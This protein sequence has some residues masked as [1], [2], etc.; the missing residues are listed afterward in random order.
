MNSFV[1]ALVALF[2]SVSASFQPLAVAELESEPPSPEAV[3]LA[4]FLAVKN[5]P[6]PAD[7][8]VQYDNWELIVALSNA[9][10]S[11]GRHMA[12]SFNAWGIKDFRSGSVKFGKTRD[13][14][15]WEESIAYTSQ[16]LYKY[17]PADGSPD[18]NRMVARWKYV[19][20][21]GHWVNNVSYS[22]S[23]IEK[24]VDNSGTEEVI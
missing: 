17:D 3:A 6:L 23:E 2:V 1:G 10:S 14:T 5:S 11:Y 12:G 16:L 21:Y 8:L 19:Q 13:F 22:L 18:P 15:S 7:L 9:E 20:P 24:H 4:E